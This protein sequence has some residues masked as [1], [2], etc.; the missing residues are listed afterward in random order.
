M[1][2]WWRFLVTSWFP[3]LDSMV[4]SSRFL[5]AWI[6]G[7]WNS[8]PGLHSFRGGTSTRYLVSSE[9]IALGSLPPLHLRRL[10]WRKQVQLMRKLHHFSYLKRHDNVPI[11]FLLN[12]LDPG[13]GGICNLSGSYSSSF[14][15]SQKLTC[16]DEAVAGCSIQLTQL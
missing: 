4:A 8:L 14:R 3:S 9:P 2:A 12:C 1:I 15:Y 6:S 10:L 16:C 13:N 7:C 11:P 5:V